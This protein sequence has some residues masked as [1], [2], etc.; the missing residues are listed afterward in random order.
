MYFFPSC[1]VILYHSPTDAMH[2][3]QNYIM[4]L[5]VWQNQKTNVRGEK[6]FNLKYSERKG[7][8]RI[9]CDFIN[10]LILTTCSTYTPSTVLCTEMHLKMLNHFNILMIFA[11]SSYSE[12]WTI[13][14]YLLLCFTKICSETFNVEFVST[15]TTNLIFRN[16]NVTGC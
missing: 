15:T 6:K 14:I 13:L 2:I 9:F 16:D 10:Y 12:C 11:I 3:L 4:A 8:R 5:C 7:V 1:M